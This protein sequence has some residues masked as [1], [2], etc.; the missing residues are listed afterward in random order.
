MILTIKLTMFGYN[1]Y[2]GYTVTKSPKFTVLNPHDP[3]DKLYYAR[4]QYAI[5]ELPSPLEFV[6]YV[7]FFP[8]V[9][10]G[11]VCTCVYFGYMCMY[12]YVYYIYLCVCIY[13]SGLGVYVLHTYYPTHDTY[14]LT[15]YIGSSYTF[16]RVI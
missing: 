14:Y 10:T 8:T 13:R 6:G 2:D 12:I 11:T 7:Y 9:L 1:V 16:P 4:V 5:H 15:C 3:R